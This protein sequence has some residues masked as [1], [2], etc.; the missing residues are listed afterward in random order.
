MTSFLHLSAELKLSVIEQLDNDIDTLLSI[1]RVCRILRLFVAPF[2]FNTV[3]LRNSEKSGRSIAALGAQDNPISLAHLVREFHYKGSIVPPVSETIGPD[4]PPKK[5]ETSDFP[6]VVDAVLGNLA[7]F[8]NLEKLVVEF[9]LDGR[10]DY[11]IYLYEDEETTEMM[12]K[13]EEDEAW[14][15]VM[16]KSWDAISR[17]HGFVKSLE[18]RNLIPKEVSTWTNESS[19]F[20]D[21]LVGLENIKISI[22]GHDNGVGWSIS[23]TEGYRYF[24][25]QLD[26]F[27]FNHLQN[28]TRFE[29]SAWEDAPPGLSDRYD[30][31]HY[32]LPLQGG[33]MP[34]LRQLVL[35]DCFISTFLADFIRSLAPTLQSLVL[36]K[37]HAGDRELVDGGQISWGNFFNFVYDAEMASLTELVV[38]LLAGTSKEESER[39]DGVT[40]FSYAEL[41]RKYGDCWARENSEEADNDWKAWTRLTRMVEEKKDV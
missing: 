15:T 29:Y 7:A 36:R 23:T 30:S 31:H 33:Q 20:R 18:I 8:P 16:A 3:V 26:V 10:Y 24:G 34:R 17:N 9:T 32:R 22:L 19:R 37:C 4:G 38:D 11:D 27:F 25:E 35:S 41:T 5:F 14:R 21:F 13:A 39:K 40:Y 12:V 2:V 6:D 1:S 28:V